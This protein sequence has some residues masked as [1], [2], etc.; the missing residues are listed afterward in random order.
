MDRARSRRSRPS[1]TA[2]RPDPSRRGQ[3]RARRGSRGC[4]T[5]A[6][7]SRRHGLGLTDRELPLRQRAADHSRRHA[8]A[9]ERAYVVEIA[10]AAA[11]VE[12]DART[13]H[14]AHGVHERERRTGE[15]AAGGEGAGAERARAGQDRGGGRGEPSAPRRDLDERAAAAARRE[16]AVAR[17]DLDDRAR[18]ET[19]DTAEE[20][21]VPEDGAREEDAREAVRDRL[22]RLVHRG[23]SAGE[24]AGHAAGARD[25]GEERRV[26]EDAG[27]G[28]VE[29]DQV[30][31]LGAVLDERPR[32]HERVGG[33]A[34]SDHATRAHVDR[35]DDHHG[36]RF[37]SAGP[38]GYRRGVG[39]TFRMTT[40]ARPGS[41]VSRPS[42]AVAVMETSSPPRAASA[43]RA[44]GS[45]ASTRPFQT[46]PSPPTWRNGRRYSAT[47][48][49]APTA[50]AVP[51]SQRP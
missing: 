39:R 12:R 14:R 9:R 17:L 47:A 10:D 28:A 44:A 22:A 49:S 42:A 2:R 5:E 13:D 21:L 6:L 15:A 7:F 36:L 29:I 35:G 27:L 3:P 34:G 48:A 30:Q 18:A 50:R 40:S 1:P 4:P 37:A 38:R 23:Q 51:S 20:I 25:R 16:E 8:A 43:R 19:R 45:A 32:E 31:L 26:R 24:P 41:T 46:I 11:R 33:L